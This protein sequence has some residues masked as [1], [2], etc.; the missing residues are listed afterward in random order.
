MSTYT[1][2]NFGYGAPQF[3]TEEERLK[4]DLKIA[5]ERLQVFNDKPSI[6]G[7]VLAVAE[8]RVTVCTGPQMVDLKRPPAMELEE[9]SIIRLQAGDPPG[10][11]SVMDHIPYTGSVVVIKQLIGDN[12]A[13]VNLR[14]EMRSVL[15]PKA[16]KAKPGDRVVLDPTGN[17][18]VKNLGQG[19]TSSAFTSE[20]GVSWKDVGGLTEAKAALIEAIEEP[21]RHKELYA[22]YGILPTRGVLLYGPPGTGKTLL[23]KACATALAEIHGASARSS[24]FLYV[25]G[26]EMLNMYVGSSEANIRALFSAAREHHAKNGYPAIVFIDEADALMGK[27]GNSRGIEGMERTIVPQFLAEMD[28]L[29]DANCMVLLATNRPDTLDPAVVRPGRVDRKIFVRRPTEFEAVS[30]FQIHL[31]RVRNAFAKEVTINSLANAGARALFD[32]KRTFYVLR[33][34]DG[35]DVRFCLKEQASGALIA[36]IVSKA[37]QQALRRERDGEKGRGVTV[38]DMTAAVQQCVEDGR[39]LD[40]TA[41]IRDFI[42]DKKLDVTKIEKVTS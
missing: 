19:D 23:G 4:Y 1:S 28:G 17:A 16:H 32:D 14:Q 26:P 30:T 15:V 37:S 3:K 6:Y 13:E 36:D 39:S 22:R 38:E 12:H 11:L 34:K 24:G 5:L 8:K 9:G 2:V 21:I 31:K 41:D 35:N 18:V 33:C 20:S 29:E 10:I 42:E 27:R 7:V 40:H 25:K